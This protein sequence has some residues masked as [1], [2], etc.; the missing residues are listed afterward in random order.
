MKLMGLCL[1]AAVCYAGGSP[2][3]QQVAPVTLFTQSQQ[4][5][6]PTVM[7]ALQ[8]EVG[9]I[10]AP[11][12]FQIDWHDIGAASEVGTVTELAV[13]TFRGVCDVTESVPYRS[14]GQAVLGFTSISDGAILPF[15]TVDCDRTRDFLAN[16][17]SRLPATERRPV[18]G[19]ALGRILAHELYHI[20]ANTKRHGSAGVAKNAYTVSDLM[21][22]EFS[23]EEREFELLRAARPPASPH[24]RKRARCR[25]EHKIAR[26]S[27]I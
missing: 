6:Q 2:R 20:F 18:Y 26:I 19:R 15:T 24:G 5:L 16:A 23:F 11:A 9:N 22:E 1:L 21:S 4:A 10:L 13:V 12:G 7:E 8:I 3:I 25:G 17:L 27:T 14:T